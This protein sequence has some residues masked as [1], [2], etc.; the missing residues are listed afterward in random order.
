MRYGPDD[1][2]AIDRSRFRRCG[3]L[4]ADRHVFLGYGRRGSRADILPIHLCDGCSRMF[5][6]WLMAPAATSGVRP[7]PTAEMAN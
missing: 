2:I 6:T 5:A 3:D 1:A 7:V 4:L